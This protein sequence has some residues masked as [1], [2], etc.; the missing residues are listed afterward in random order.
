MGGFLLLVIVILYTI[1]LSFKDWK[2]ML[3][4]FMWTSFPWNGIYRKHCEL[5]S[6]ANTWT[7]PKLL[8]VICLLVLSIQSLYLEARGW[9]KGERLENNIEELW[10]GYQDHRHT[11]PK[12]EAF[13]PRIYFTLH[14]LLQKNRPPSW[15]F[16]ICNIVAKLWHTVTTITILTLR[17]S[18]MH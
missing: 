18:E 7:C 10:V 6:W 11:F 5:T 4:S 14:F 15:I 3:K 8:N 1:L 12:V 2:A 16:K 9:T 13:A 17:E